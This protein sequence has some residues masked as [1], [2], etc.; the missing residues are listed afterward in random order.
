MELTIPELQQILAELHLVKAELENI[1]NINLRQEWYTDEQCWQ[2]KGGCAL[3]TFRKRKDLQVK[4]GIPDGKICGRNAWKKE[5]VLE[6]LSV[7]D[8]DFPEYKRKV[9]AELKAR[10][11]K[12]IER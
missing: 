2:L 11:E 9:L 10:N 5:S 1:R 12:R 8:E 7:S 3:G 6:W 4:C